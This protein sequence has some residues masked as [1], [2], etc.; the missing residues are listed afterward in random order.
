LEEGEREQVPSREQTIFD[1]L[2]SEEAGD[3]NP[4]NFCNW[5][6]L[7]NGEKKAKK[8]ALMAVIRGTHRGM[9]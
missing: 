5:R 3:T 1:E 7:S 8:Y 4:N 6:V 2:S 9:R